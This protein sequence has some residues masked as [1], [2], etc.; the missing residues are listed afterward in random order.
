MSTRPNV[1]DIVLYHMPDKWHPELGIRI[2]PGIVLY[3]NPSWG[4]TGIDIQ[5]FCQPYEPEH[6]YHVSAAWGYEAG[7][8]R[9]K[10]HSDD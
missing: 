7:Q 6:G 2:Y 4:P 9:N 1:G 5:V 3:G 10:S 8:W